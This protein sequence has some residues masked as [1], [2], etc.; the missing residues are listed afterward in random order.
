MKPRLSQAKPDIVEKY[1][2]W[3]CSLPKDNNPTINNDGDIDESEN[4]RHDAGEFFFLSF[5]LGGSKQRNCTVPKEKK[6]IL[7]PSLCFLA[8]EAEAKRSR[9]TASLKKF[10]ET[11]HDN[12]EYRSIEIDGNPI[13]GNIDRYRVEADNFTVK[14]SHNPIFN[15]GPGEECKAAADGAYVVWEPEGPGQH[16]IHFKGKV[17]V[18]DDERP[19]LEGRAYEEDVTYTLTIP[20]VNST[21]Q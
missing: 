12:I 19:C 2:K 8:S 18:P 5:V 21:Q 13:V 4:Q 10:A 16:I 6:K 1:W 3:L 15:A 17:G 9:H 11:D 14:Y 20:N 7:I